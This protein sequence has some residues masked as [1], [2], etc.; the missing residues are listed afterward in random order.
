MKYQLGTIKTLNFG[1]DVPDEIEAPIFKLKIKNQDQKYIY[2]KECRYIPLAKKVIAELDT[3]DLLPSDKNYFIQLELFRDDR[4]QNEVLW[5]EQLWVERGSS[6]KK[7]V[8]KSEVKKK[9]KKRPTFIKEE[10]P[11]TFESVKQDSQTRTG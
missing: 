11:E 8:K 4:L 9:V 2:S 7:I 10:K 6:D 3:Y 5:V 1:V